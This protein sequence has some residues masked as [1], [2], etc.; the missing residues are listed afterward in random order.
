MAEIFLGRRVTEVHGF[1]KLV[2][3]KR[4]LPQYAAL[5]KFRRMFLDEARIAATLHHSNIVAV[6]DVG[7][8]DGEY[9]LVMEYVDGKDARAVLHSAEE[10]RRRIPLPV[11]LAIVS[12][13]AAG[14]HYAHEKRGRDGRAIGVVHRDVSP[15]NILVAYDGCVRVTDFGIAKALSSTAQTRTGSLKGKVAY[16]SPEQC[17]AEHLDRRSDVFALG[18]VL[19]EL[20]AG[21]RPY[22]GTSEYETMHAIVSADAPLPSSLRHDYPSALER[23][24]QRALRRPRDE[25]YETA[26]ELQLAIE[27]FAS[28]TGLV[29]S[30]A[31]VAHTMRKLFRDAAP[32]PAPTASPKGV[33]NQSSRAGVTAPTQLLDAPAGTSADT[34]P[35]PAA[36]PS[37]SDLSRALTLRLASPR[38]ARS[39][40]PRIGALLFVAAAILLLALWAGRRGSSP[41]PLPVA[42]TT[43]DAVL[44]GPAPDPVVSPEQPAPGS[45]APAATAP[46]AAPA[47]SVPAASRPMNARGRPTGQP[48]RPPSAAS[49]SATPW[50]P[51]SP[52]PF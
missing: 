46:A 12:A 32:A 34:T 9:F 50:N 1:E 31:V 26:E 40:V 48:R 24:V 7:Q 38:G 11:A 6:H 17:L 2:V 10:E 41:S 19:Y 39:A 18:I 47:D 25:R 14:L 42:S 16:M 5:E 20:T 36:P 21:R 29:L 52:L 27:R 4:I 37:R 28:D 33:A 23:I 15:S 13:A 3:L 45:A 30:T 51:D 43:E 44:R 8:V 22:L 49:A 35:N